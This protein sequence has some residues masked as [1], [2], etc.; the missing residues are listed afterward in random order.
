MIPRTGIVSDVL[1]T[2]QK[3]ASISD[4]VMAQCCEFTR[5]TVESFSKYLPMD[6][7]ILS[8]NR[9]LR[10]IRGALPGR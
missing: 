1:A 3:K 4:E 7:S 6:Y 9:I 5:P 10:S 2:L 8:I